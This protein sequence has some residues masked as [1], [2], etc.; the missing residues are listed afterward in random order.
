MVISKKETIE[1]EDLPP[2]TVGKSRKYSN[3]KAA[4]REFKKEFIAAAL[5]Q[6][7]GN[8]SKTARALGINRSFLVQLIKEFGLK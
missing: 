7:D 2:Q 1:P 6:Y 3:M 5:K 4:C 8:R